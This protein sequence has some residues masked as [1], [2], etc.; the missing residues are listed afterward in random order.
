MKKHL[1]SWLALGILIVTGCQKETSFELS[2][3]PAEGSLQSDISGDCLPKTI[4]GVYS[5]GVV[6]N[7][8]NNTIIVQVDVT[9]TGNYIV[10][11]DTVNGYYFRATGTFTTLGAT[12][13]TLRGNGTPFASGV[14]NFVVSFDSTVCDI[15]VTVATAAAYTLV[16]G[17][18]PSN[19]ASA[20]V[21][22]T[23]VKDAPTNSSNFVDIT[24]NV[25][26]IGAYSI[27]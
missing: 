8:T 19:C 13:V 22:G 27:R 26:S 15:Q 20:A 16:A 17:G 24:V 25:T 14:N 23:Y 4:N 9:K 7:P 3:V 1:F 11:A 12:N 21:S 5:A 6:L 2:N 18:T 10:S